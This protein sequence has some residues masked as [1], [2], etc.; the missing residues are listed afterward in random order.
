LR[1][2]KLTALQEHAPDAIATANVGCEL[3]LRNAATVPV[4]HWLE[5]ID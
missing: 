3:H 5:L 4:R 2:R 1:E